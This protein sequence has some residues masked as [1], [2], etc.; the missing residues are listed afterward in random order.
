WIDSLC[1]VQ[2]SAED[3]QR[4]SAQMATI[5]TNAYLTLFTDCARDDGAGFLRPRSAWKYTAV[6]LPFADNVETGDAAH[7]A[8]RGWISQE[9][10]LSRR[11]LHF[12]R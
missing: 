1:I 6:T 3:W 8:D 5:Y 10:V 12:G 7:L 11:I 4:Q 9:R 2:D